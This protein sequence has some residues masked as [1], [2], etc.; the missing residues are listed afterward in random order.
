MKH[1]LPFLVV[2]AVLVLAGL[3]ICLFF[4]PKDGASNADGGHPPGKPLPAPQTERIHSDDAAELLDALGREGIRVVP[5]VK[6][7]GDGFVKITAEL[8]SV[9]ELDRPVVVAGVPGASEFQKVESTTAEFWFPSGAT[10]LISGSAAG[11]FAARRTITATEGLHCVL[12]IGPYG[13]V[14]GIVLM[15]DGSGAE[16]AYVELGPADESAEL[17]MRTTMAEKGGVFIFRKVQPGRYVIQARKRPLA[18]SQTRVVTVLALESIQNFNL[19]LSD[20]PSLQGLVVDAETGAPLA[21]ARVEAVAADGPTIGEAVTNEDGGF[22]FSLRRKADA[23]RLAVQRIGYAAVVLDTPLPASGDLRVG[24]RPVGDSL[25]VKVLDKT[26]GMR[27]AGAEIS[28]TAE[29]QAGNDGPPALTATTGAD[30]LA[31][32]PRIGIG[33]HW[34]EATLPG[35]ISNERRFT[36]DQGMGAVSVTL[37]LQP[38]STVHVVFADPSGRPLAREVSNTFWLL[39]PRARQFDR[40]LDLPADLAFGAGRQGF[41]FGAVPPG[42]Y[43]LY[44]FAAGFLPARHLIVVPEGGAVDTAIVSRLVAREPHPL[45]IE[46]SAELSVLRGAQP[47]LPPARKS[48]DLRG[49]NTQPLIIEG[50]IERGAARMVARMLATGEFSDSYSEVPVAWHEGWTSTPKLDARDGITLVMPT[51]HAIVCHPKGD[52]SSRVEPVFAGLASISGTLDLSGVSLQEGETLLVAACPVGSAN[53]PLPAINAMDC[54]W[55]PVARDAA[56]YRLNYLPAED[57][58]VLLFTAPTGTPD[59]TH[60]WNGTDYYVPVTLMPGSNQRVD[61]P[62]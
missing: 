15:P 17:K 26:S 6:S 52:D 60:T 35:Y 25:T 11:H 37:E 48:G 14:S 8:V 22:D 40:K 13:E 34:A 16:G 59:G 42:E 43:D 31:F 54:T 10:V 20:M 47:E 12:E 3:S 49:V 55:T 27:L 21:L 9:A 44:V 36:V 38:E 53:E 23:V 62:K 5:A 39:Y 19:Q 28:L 7:S 4:L 41:E 57:Y 1:R 50:S 18:P 24:L 30:G 46:K 58:V 61:L 33:N 2:L 32:F 51:G 29:V 45:T 56:E